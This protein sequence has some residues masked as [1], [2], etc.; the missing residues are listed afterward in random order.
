MDLDG[1]PRIVAIFGTN[2]DMGAFE[3]FV[4]Q[5]TLFRVH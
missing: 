1:N 5:G 3:Y 4:R 2:V